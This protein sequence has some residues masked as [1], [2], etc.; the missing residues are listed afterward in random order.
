[1]PR[2]VAA[3]QD[4]EPAEPSTKPQFPSPSQSPISLDWS[5]PAGCPEGDAVSADVIRLSGAT[6][7]GSRHLKARASIR[8]ADGKGWILSLATDL[9][10]ATGER[11]LVGASCES[12]TEAATL[13]LALILNP[14]LAV[15]PP[16]PAGDQRPAQEAATVASTSDRRLHLVWRLGAHAGIQA[17]AIE[18]L[19]SCF[20]LSLGVGLGRLSLRLM[21]GLTPPQNIFVDAAR[22]LG[23]RL[24]VGTAAALGCWAAAVGPVTLSP[25]LGF[26]VARL[27]G[28]GLGVLQPR[29]KTVYW[30]S[31]EL[32]V[33]AG[34]PVGY[35]VALEVGGI[36]VLPFSRPTV[37]LDGIGP[38]SRPAVFGFRAL[39]GLAWV[40]E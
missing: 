11:T 1:M 25:C 15:P 23:G 34:L 5:T 38:V 31:A 40:F 39:G 29:E 21:P 22:T 26:D 27:Q 13:T 2:S 32:A 16:P 36:G 24:W 12:L 14:D 8:P 3:A 18:N 37:Y 4:Q 28:H 9:N 10:G 33:F 7:Q 19:S 20:A 35:G 6:A 30:S 17:G